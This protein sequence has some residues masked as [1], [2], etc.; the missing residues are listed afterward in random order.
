MTVDGGDDAGRHG[1]VG[2]MSVMLS[3]TRRAA[4]LSGLAIGLCTVLGAC[5]STGETTTAATITIL[6]QSYQ[7][8]PPPT[9]ETQDL[10]PA[11]AGEDGRTSDTQ[12]YIVLVGD[13]PST[14][15]QKFGISTSEL[16]A[17]NDWELVGDIAPDFPGPGGTVRIPE[18]ALVPSADDEEETDET[19]EVETGDTTSDGAIIESPP[20]NI[21]DDASEDRCVPGRYTLV[22]NDFPGSVAKKFDVSVDDLAAANRSTPNYNSFIVGIEIIIPAADDC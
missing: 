18:G 6:P 17:F 14:V 15:A 9:V 22:T 20:T 7:S 19:N 11:T 21:I 12:T 4:A 5:G 8:K 16:L 10:T 3:R 13:Y 2:N 1:P